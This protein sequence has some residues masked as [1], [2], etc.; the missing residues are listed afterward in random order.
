MVGRPTEDLGIIRV[1]V[2]YQNDFYGQPG[3]DGVVNA[4][5]QRGLETAAHWHYQRNSDAVKAAVFNIVEAN[6][7]V[8]IIIGAYAPVA[9]AITAARENID[10]I[11]MA[12]SFV[13]SNALAQ[14]LGP[15]G[16]GI[17]VHQVVPLPDNTSVPAVADYRAALDTFDANAEPGR[18]FGRL[19]GRVLGN[20]RS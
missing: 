16:A 11:F 6:P 8:V 18:I 19:F 5:R 17:Y 3:L 2:M 15:D 9:K 7:Q 1:A 10:P 14:E 4:L 13:S 20:H 12:V